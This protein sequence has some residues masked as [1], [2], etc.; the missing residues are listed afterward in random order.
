MMIYTVRKA[1]IEVRTY[2]IENM[3]TLKSQNTVRCLCIIFFEEAVEG[4]NLNLEGD[5]PPNDS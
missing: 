5:V 2:E 4:H 3:H 1:Y